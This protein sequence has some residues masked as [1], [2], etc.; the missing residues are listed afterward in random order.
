[1]SLEHLAQ[2]GTLTGPR[3]GLAGVPL[4]IRGA[5]GSAIQALAI[6][7]DTGAET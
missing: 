2:L 7:E 6:F 5:T 4:R 3:F 1:M